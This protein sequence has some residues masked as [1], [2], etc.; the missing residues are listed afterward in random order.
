MPG[1]GLVGGTGPIVL[2]SRDVL[3]VVLL[4]MG[5]LLLVVVLAGL[6]DGRVV[7]RREGGH[8]RG[9]VCESIC[10]EL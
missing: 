2:K 1:I 9:F 10:L 8:G 4:A 5:G 6:V 7:G 3:V